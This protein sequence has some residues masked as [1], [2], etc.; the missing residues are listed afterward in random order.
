MSG[1]VT[2]PS[3]GIIAGATVTATSLATGQSRT[4]TTD[5]SGA[6]K[7]SLL[8]PG[9]YGVKFSA[10]GFK[11]AE[12]PSITVDITETPDTESQP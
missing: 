1:T 10:S 12:V 3:G 8:P 7:F 9:N 11:T 6:Y 4:T 2:D 5:A